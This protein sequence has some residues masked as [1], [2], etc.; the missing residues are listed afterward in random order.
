MLRKV[1]HI[2]VS[3]LL[4]VT[5][6]GFTI[7]RHYCKANLVSVSIYGN[8]T[9]CNHNDHDN[10]CNDSKDYFQVE[11]DFDLKESSFLPDLT[12]HKYSLFSAVN[13]FVAQEYSIQNFQIAVL[14]FP[15]SDQPDLS[16]LQHFLL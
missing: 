11:D 14:K 6:A 13:L 4:L 9:P 7:S 3:L 16:K 2:I 5:T 15:L 8:A 12:A 10:C 1:I